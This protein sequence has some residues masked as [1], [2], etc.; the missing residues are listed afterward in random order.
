MELKLTITLYVNGD[1]TNCF[2]H[3]PVYII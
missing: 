2:E 3:I 1:S